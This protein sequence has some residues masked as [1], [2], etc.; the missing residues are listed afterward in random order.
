MADIID[1]GS[2]FW[3]LD[4]TPKKEHTKSFGA[5][6]KN[7]S[8][9]IETALISDSIHDTS[10]NS[11]FPNGKITK[12]IPPYSKDTSKSRYTVL[13][14]RPDN[15][16]IKNV[17]ITSDKQ[18]GELFL[19][20]CLFMRERAALLDRHATS[21]EYAPFYS[22]SPRYSQLTKA[23]LKWYLWYRENARNGI[24]LP[25]DESYII[26][27]AY[28]LVASADDTREQALSILCSLL[29]EYSSKELS[30]TS[31]MIIR[32]MIC[33]FCL[34]HNLPAPTSKLSHLEKQIL[35]GSF[36]YEF[37]I[38]ISSKSVDERSRL[39][40]DHISL[41]DFKRSKYYTDETSAVFD[42][43]IGGALNAIL[44]SQE[45][46]NAL[47]SYT[48][49]AYG[50]ITLERKPLNRMV[51]IIN[52]GITLNITYFELSAMRA[53]ITDIVRYC[54]NRVRAHL[55]IKNKLN[56]LSVN[57]AAK[58][59]A[60]SFFDIHFPHC[61]IENGKQVNSPLGCK[62]QNEYD[63]LYDVP[64][65]GASAER[66]LEIE[67]ASWSTTK[68]LT[69]A[70]TDEHCSDNCTCEQIASNEIGSNNA[71]NSTDTDNTASTMSDIYSQIMQSVG[72]L[73]KFIDACKNVNSYA[74]QCS[75]ARLKGLSVDVIADKIN[76][77]A[78]NTFG[79]IILE[80]TDLGYKIIDDYRNMVINDDSE[81]GTNVNE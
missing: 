80:N 13:E 27:Y 39:I 4:D 43:A 56:I 32:D 49:G 3:N 7:R 60:D 68:I 44:D 10:T 2:A 54:E 72:E 59:A 23:Q 53:P 55:G 75:F 15:L 14:Y 11:T 17:K 62:K 64:L 22:Y 77:A 25:T 33:D 28:E 65:T 81:K 19:N 37:F 67:R 9:K 24:F 34:L 73:A 36:L 35:S 50:D 8:S 66:A 40:S 21:A 41:Y 48:N 76:E 69:E 58:N 5:T 1:D 16:F 6:A 61:T 74:Q 18:N 45:A 51:N 38:D 26:L 57:P 78:V 63:K 30:I 20:D 29:T 12:F 46:F 42:N 71:T 47:I 70:F 79:D 31:K 52:R